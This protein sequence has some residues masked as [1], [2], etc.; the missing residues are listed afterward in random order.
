MNRVNDLEPDDEAQT[1]T[2]LRPSKRAPFRWPFK[3]NMV[4]AG[5][6]LFICAVGVGCAYLILSNH[7]ISQGFTLN[8]AKTRVAELT[9]QNQELE[10]AVMQG[11][12]YERV[13]G[14][15]AALGMVAVGNVEYVEIK[16][17]GVAMR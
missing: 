3:F 14:R 2:A 15:I 7:L 17:S 12:S 16:N 6:F 10:L 8:T 1:E 13:S 11:E 9:K 5:A 4:T